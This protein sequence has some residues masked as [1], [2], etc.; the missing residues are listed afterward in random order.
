MVIV[1]YPFAL[2]TVRIHFI[3]DNSKMEN[4]NNFD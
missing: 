3:I 1:H 4:I 2:T